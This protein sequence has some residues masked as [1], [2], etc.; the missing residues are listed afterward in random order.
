VRCCNKDDLKCLAK[1]TGGKVVVTM[2][3]MEGETVLMKK[4]SNC[5]AAREV[6]R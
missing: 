3:D 5:S 4:V 6:R 2:A 1:A